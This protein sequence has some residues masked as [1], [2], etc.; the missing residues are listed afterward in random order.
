M[1]DV[2][3]FV[4]DYQLRYTKDEQPFS[5]KIE[6]EDMYWISFYNRKN[7]L[8]KGSREYHEEITELYKKEAHR[9]FD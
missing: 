6:P 4:R 3:E 1:D 2:I 8:M 5:Y 7:E 9:L